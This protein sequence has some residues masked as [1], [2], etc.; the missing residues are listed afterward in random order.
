MAAIEEIGKFEPFAKIRRI[1]G[2]PSDGCG[3]VWYQIFSG[4]FS[5]HLL[6]AEYKTGQLHEARRVET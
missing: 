4:P 1:G 6:A 5:K 2:E 3:H